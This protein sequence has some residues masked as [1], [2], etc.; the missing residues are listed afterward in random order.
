MSR[1]RHDIQQN[2]T[3]LNDTRQND[4]QRNIATLRGTL[5]SYFC[6]F[7]LTCG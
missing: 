7:S 3:P 6:V 2:D 5:K 1:R 4:T